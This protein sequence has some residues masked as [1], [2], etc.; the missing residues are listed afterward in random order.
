M[1]CPKLRF[2]KTGKHLRKAFGHPA[3]CGA[4]LVDFY[5]KA[6]MSKGVSLFCIPIG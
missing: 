2:P 4:R 6:M 1:G 5:K 3:C